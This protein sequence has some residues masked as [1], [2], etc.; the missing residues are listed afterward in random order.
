ME[1][2]TAHAESTTSTFLYLL[3]SLLGLSSSTTF[4]HAAS[5]L[6]VAQCIHVLLRALPY[7][8]S[9]GRMVI[10]AELTARHGVRQE[11]VFRRGGNADGISDAVFEFAT[12]ANDNLLTAREMFKQ[13]GGDGG[14]VPRHAMPVFLYGVRP[15]MYL[16]L[17]DV[18]GPGRKDADGLS[19][20][21]TATDA[22]IPRTPRG[23]QF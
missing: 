9:K 13:S 22:R 3:L 6:G 12:V 21:L 5:H 1:S 10:P 2:L 15:S 23:S 18:R 7:H 4:S 16:E 20:D 19:P 17:T 14:K 11:D 8:A